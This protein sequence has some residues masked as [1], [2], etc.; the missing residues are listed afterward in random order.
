MRKKFPSAAL[1]L[2]LLL[3]AVAATLFVNLGRANPYSQ[4]VYK[5]EIA[6][7][8]KPTITIP[9]PKNNSI[10]NTNG[11]SIIL[12]VSIKKT[13]NQN[14]QEFISRVYYKSDWLQDDTYVYKYYNPDSN[15]IRPQIT[16]FYYCLNLTEIPAGKH[17]VAFY[18][19]EAGYYFPS[20][21]EYYG[22]STNDS[23]VISFTI[24]TT[25]PSVSVLSLENKTYD[26][27]D[28]P[29]NFT[30]NE[31]AQISYV[32]DGQE[33]VTIA[34]NI[35][36]TGLPNGDHNV[37]VYATDEAGNVGGSETISFT[38]DKKPEP[39]PVV[40]VAAA[41]VAAVAVAGAGLLV[42]FKKRKH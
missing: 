18:A 37:T 5:G 20:L 7:P 39:F 8:S 42:Y 33:N 1:I 12:N 16:E 31:S 19:I 10:Y 28:V 24:D 3:S 32:L 40:P 2:A 21:F 9:S 14:Y 6:P 25:S 4:A 29:L 11:L 36:L 17:N 15:Y 30:V 38:I 34:G 13:N 22:F 35:T 41:S 26:T 23:S 27:S